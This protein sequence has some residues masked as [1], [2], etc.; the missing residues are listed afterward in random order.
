MSAT[1]Q[2]MTFLASKK[3]FADGSVSFGGDGTSDTLRVTSAAGGFPVGSDSRQFEFWAKID[4]TYTTWSNIFSYGASSAGACF[5]L[6]IRN[7]Q[8]TNFSFTGFSSGD[9]SG[10]G[11]QVSGYV[12]AWHHYCLT[13]DGTTVEFFID[14]TS[15][16]TGTRTLDTGGTVFPIGGS[17][18][19]GFGENFKGLI[20]NFRVL[21]NVLYTS[22]F[23]VP[24]S[25][26]TATSQGA[27]GCVLLC[28]QDSNNIT[29]AAVKPG[30][31]TAHGSSITGSTDK[32]F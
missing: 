24:T 22:N 4:S 5:G 11:P 1:L 10:I 21:E 16:G 19:S 2:A 13:Y 31:L 12:N 32:P 28:C 18:H 23:T 27:S 17:E 20:Y 26:L 9:I 8:N 6:N 29:D 30:N 15:Q 7:N 25:A 3:P 14:G